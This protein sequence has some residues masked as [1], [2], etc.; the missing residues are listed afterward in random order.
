M[1]NVWIKNYEKYSFEKKLFLYTVTVIHI[2]VYL[3]ETE[4]LEHGDLSENL[5]SYML[6]VNDQRDN[7]VQRGRL[8]Y[9][10]VDTFIF[11]IR[12]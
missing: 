8:C 3:L 1:Y 2:F 11:I 7:W 9:I 10:Y 6:G 5:E 12:K 4:E